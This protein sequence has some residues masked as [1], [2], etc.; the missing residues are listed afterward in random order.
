MSTEAVAIVGA[1]LAQSIAFGF[2]G[3][4]LHR[5]V[6]QHDWEINGAQGLRAS[7]HEHATMLT[8]HEYRISDL[9]RL[10]RQAE[11]DEHGRS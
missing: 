1:L 10:E 8:Q 2:W 11:G 4:N 9:E 5:L 7:R 3:G 6:K